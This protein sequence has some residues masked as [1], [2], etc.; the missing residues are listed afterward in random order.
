MDP[1]R[2]HFDPI[3]FTFL[4]VFKCKKCLQII[5]RK[6]TKNLKEAKVLK[7]EGF[8]VI[9]VLSWHS[10]D[11]KYSELCPYVLKTDGSGV[12]N[13]PAGILFENVWQ[14]SKCYPKAYDIKVK[15]NHMSNIIHWTYTCSGGVEDH[16]ING[17]IQPK[18]YEWRDSICNCPNPIRYPV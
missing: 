14:S 8:E 15:P 5:T 10:K 3:N 1:Y 11:T 7:V 16:C 6:R 13:F 2:C 12:F 18:Y 4:I 17:Q 9:N